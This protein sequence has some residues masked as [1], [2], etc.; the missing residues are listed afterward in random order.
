MFAYTY[1]NPY[2]KLNIGQASWLKNR[3]CRAGRQAKSGG[4][5]GQ[6]QHC[7]SL[8]LIL[9]REDAS[10]VKFLHLRMCD[11]NLA[12]FNLA[13]GM[14]RLAVPITRDATPIGPGTQLVIGVTIEI[15]F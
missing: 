13:P 14:I 11:V 12:C 3:A 9:R 7:C 5:A 8:S 1:D 10:S 4:Q 15:A 2:V 6:K